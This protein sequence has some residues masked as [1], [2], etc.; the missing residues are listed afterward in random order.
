MPDKKVVM[1]MLE[2]HAQ[3]NGQS[4]VGFLKSKGWTQQ[5]HLPCAWQYVC[6]LAGKHAVRSEIAAEADRALAA[7]LQA[8]ADANHIE[9]QKKLVEEAQNKAQQLEKAQR[10]EKAQQLEK[11]AAQKAQQLEENRKKAEWDAARRQKEDMEA[12]LSQQKESIKG[13]MW[14]A[15]CALQADQPEVSTNN[16][17]D[18]LA[19]VDNLIAAEDS[20][21]SQ[22][23]G[24]GSVPPSK[25]SEMIAAAPPQGI[26]P[27]PQSRDELIAAAASQK[28]QSISQ[29]LMSAIPP[30]PK[31]APQDAPVSSPKDAP[32]QSPN[33]AP[34]QSPTTDGTACNDIDGGE[35]KE[36]CKRKSNCIHMM[37]HPRR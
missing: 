19:M 20:L 24:M 14:D 4:L 2:E 25:V 6:A 11:A 26:V 27:P 17:V 22:I 29:L 7:K 31:P 23:P 18:T 35:D 16:I 34:V 36:N 9:A 15:S 37:E 1:D 12:A 10:L 33:G 3:S 21:P 30:A 8:E 32:V 13:S 5:K 28:S